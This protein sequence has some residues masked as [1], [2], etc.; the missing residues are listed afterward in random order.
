MEEEGSGSGSGFSPMR[1]I[2]TFDFFAKK[3]SSS[4]TTSKNVGVGHD[5]SNVVVDD[6]EESVVA[7]HIGLPSF[8]NSKKNSS[9]HDYGEKGANSA[10]TTT[11]QY[12]IPTPAQ[13]VVGFTHFSCHICNKTFNRY[14]NLQVR[15]ILL[16]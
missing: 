1:N 8:C 6:N 4:S 7:L 15:V 11:T 13:I 2:E 5:Q 10:A 3:T 9:H 16:T 14:N 12:W